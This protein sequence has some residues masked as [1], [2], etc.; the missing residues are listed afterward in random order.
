MRFRSLILATALLGFA[1]GWVVAQTPHGPWVGLRVWVHDYLTGRSFL[2]KPMESDFHIVED[3]TGNSDGM[4][5]VRWENCPAP[6]TNPSGEIRV[7]QLRGAAEP[8]LV[9]LDATGKGMLVRPGPFVGIENGYL[10][11]TATLTLTRQYGVVLTRSAG[12]DYPL[13]TELQNLTVVYRNGLRQTPEVDYRIENGAVA[14]LGVAW[15][16]NDVVVVDGEKLY[17]PSGLAP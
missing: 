9:V 2:Y 4:F 16:E 14:P 6:Q 5:G 3:P 1:S 11:V 12:G 8:A 7:E 10:N 13:S 17:R 15:G